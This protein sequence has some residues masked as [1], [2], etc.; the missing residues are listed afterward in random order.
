MNLR[1][2]MVLMAL[3]TPLVVFATGCSWASGDASSP[4]SVSSSISPPANKSPSTP[5]LSPT[6]TLSST[7]TPTPTATLT[8]TATQTPTPTSTITPSPT[9]TPTLRWVN[10][11]CNRQF[12]V[13]PLP[14]HGRNSWQGNDN[15]RWTLDG[16]QILF[17]FGDEK[18]GIYA[19]DTDGSRLQ[20]IVDPSIN[21]VKANRGP[22]IGLM[23]YFDISPDGSQIVYSTC[24]YPDSD[25]LPPSGLEPWEFSYEIVVANIDGTNTR[26]I[27]N[28]DYF[29]NFPVWS[30]DG[31]QIAFV[32]DLDPDH[33]PDNS[34]EWRPIVTNRGANDVR[35]RLMVY[36]IATGESKDITPFY[37][38]RVAPHP[39]AWSPD[40]Q[41]IAFVA[42]DIDV[43]SQEDAGLLTPL[44]VYTVKPDGSGGQRVSRAFSEPS[45]SPDGARIAM[46]APWAD[47]V[48]LYTFAPD[49]SDPIFVTYAVDSVWYRTRLNG[50]SPV[51][52]RTWLNRVYWSPDGYQ[53]MFT[54][55]G[56][57]DLYYYDDPYAFESWDGSF[58]ESWGPPYAFDA[59]DKSCRG[60]CLAS[61]DGAFV[62][63][64]LGLRIPS[65]KDGIRGDSFRP[66]LPGPMSWSPDGSRIAVLT[67]TNRGDGSA[68][69]YTMDRHGKDVR[70]LV[71]L[72]EDWDLIA[73]K[74]ETVDLDSCSN[75]VVVPDP[76]KNTGLVEDCRTL[77]T[78]RD[79]LGGSVSLELSLGWSTD[80][81]ITEWGASHYFEHAVG[82]GGDPPRIRSLNLRAVTGIDGPPLYTLFGRI[83][84]ELAN[85][86]ELRTLG[87]E[88]NELTGPI[89]PE[90]GKLTNL[91]GLNLSDNYLRGNIPAELGNLTNLRYLG[92]SGN[93]LT[94]SIPAELGNLPNLERLDLVS[95][96]RESNRFTGCVP[97]ALVD[98][99]VDFDRLGLPPCEQASDGR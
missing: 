57:R 43:E 35:G 50:E 7:S 3:L 18:A 22:Y 15:V 55:D 60:I 23:T 44:S 11:P 10:T 56:Y 32:S 90:L 53:I 75:G 66:F 47:G 29:D 86:S 40:G 12:V 64:S 8:F 49:G 79:V 63:S 24:R 36:T 70:V 26:R 20:T 30:P 83:P 87:L 65:W 45:W 78:V 72:D 93:Q 6:T 5:T 62:T 34:D 89:P 59:E 80:Q 2:Y 9:P 99:I 67:R 73:W 25:S 38:A 68:V 42:Y 77:L 98:K 69:L 88:L 33:G 94:G 97:M 48:G 37:S 76:A 95:T 41:R 82:V 28:N 13:G 81:P 17:T 19:V 96:G 16:S 51:W 58:V 85:L 14:L 39:P 52:Y 4:T 1:P 21:T 84:P 31:S 71:R 46:V 92:L 74:P 54:G 27:T 61:A 91:E